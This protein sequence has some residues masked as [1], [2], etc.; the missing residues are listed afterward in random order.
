MRACWYVLVVSRFSHVFSWLKC[1]FE[2]RDLMACFY[3]SS[4]VWRCMCGR[5]WDWLWEGWTQWL[6]DKV[7]ERWFY[8]RTLSFLVRFSVTAMERGKREEECLWI[9][10]RLPHGV[11]VAF[12]TVS[13]ILLLHLCLGVLFCFDFSFPVIGFLWHTVETNKR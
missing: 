3:P 9:T 2:D 12:W 10:L 6:F 8:K 5:W 11:S 4:Q 7:V 1:R 13:L